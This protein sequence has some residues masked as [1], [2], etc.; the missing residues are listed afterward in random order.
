MAQDSDSVEISYEVAELLKN[1][2]HTWMDYDDKIKQLGD[3]RK[4]Y[5]VAKKKKEETIIKILSSICDDDMPPIEIVDPES[6]KLRGK[7]SKIKKVQPSPYNVKCIK[8][9]L[10]EIYKDEEAVSDIL[11]RINNKRTV[12]DIQKLKRTNPRQKKKAVGK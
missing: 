11:T 5:V 7:I 6:G 8:S 12:K 9:A 1:E 2:V 3:K 10:M 4:K